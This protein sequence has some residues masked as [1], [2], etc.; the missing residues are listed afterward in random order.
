MPSAGS[1]AYLVLSA[2]GA[3]NTAVAWRPPSRRRTL[4]GTLAFATG[5]ITSEFPVPVIGVQA[6]LT[7][8]AA[9]LGWIAGWAGIL[10]LVLT[11]LSW[12]GLGALRKASADARPVLDGALAEALGPGYP[13]RVLH[14]RTPGAD[15][16]TIGRPVAWRLLGIRSRYARDKDIPYGPVPTFNLLDVWRHPDLASDARAP[17]LIQ[18]PGGAWTTG[19]KQVQAYP[20]MSHMVE[21]GWVCVPV[22]YRLSPKAAWPAH[23]IDV[24]AALAWVKDHIADYGGDPEFI[25]VT[26]G[27]AGGHLSSLAGLA[28]GAP[29]FRGQ[30]APAAAPV[31]GAVPLYGFYDWTNRDGLGHRY[32]V[33]HLERK[34]VQQQITAAREIFDR[35]SPMSQVSPA[36]PPFFVLHGRNDSMIP[37]EQARRFVRL[38]RAASAQPVAYAE[39][40]RAQHAFDVLGS[41]RAR[42]AVAAVGDFL[43]VLYGDYR[44]GRTDVSAEQFDGEQLKGEQLKAEQLKG[45]PQGSLPKQVSQ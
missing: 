24:N 6:V 35:A 31:A 22:S 19:N 27:S 29:A 7:A 20:L 38:L 18:V 10:G 3:A 44:R 28:P 21:R 8:I 25:V 36:A 42:H 4:P 33:P 45:E 5:M 26:G 11:A 41:V 12:I 40:P 1:I 14:P 39:L 16:A 2:L 43:G 23:I 32:G 30:D 15:A 37:V 9:A 34:V 17:V 13:D